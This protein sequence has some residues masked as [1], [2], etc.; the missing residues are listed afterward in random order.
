VFVVGFMA[1]FAWSVLTGVRL[2][3]GDRRGWKWGLILFMAQIPVLTVPGMSYE[4]YTGIAIK[5]MAGHIEDHFQMG[6][7]TYVNAY[8][9]TRITD[10]NYG[11]NLFAVAAALFLFWKKPRHFQQ[12]T[13]LASDPTTG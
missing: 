3:R 2:W 5:V 4:F 10:L 7:G 13:E 11:V 1:V 12:L 6:F 9:D 8:L